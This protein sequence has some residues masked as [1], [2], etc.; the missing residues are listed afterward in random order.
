MVSQVAFVSLP[1]ACVDTHDH[2][3]VPKIL[4]CL[5]ET[6][7]EPEVAD[8]DDFVTARVCGSLIL[9]WAFAPALAHRAQSDIAVRVPWLLQAAAPSL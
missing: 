3:L 6:E 9:T 4:C 2:Q 1:I 7:H 8:E 5:A